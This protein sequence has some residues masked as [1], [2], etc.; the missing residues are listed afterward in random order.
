MNC[1]YYDSLTSKT[2]T[3]KDIFDIYI[4]ISQGTFQ[5]QTDFIQNKWEQE[6][7]FGFDNNQKT[8][9]QDDKKNMLPCVVFSGCYD[10]YKSIEEQTAV[11]HSGRMNMDIDMN[12]RIEL[13]E[14]NKVVLSGR[15][16]FIEACG[17]SVSGKFN[18]SMWINVLIELP[19]SYNELTEYI[20]DKLKL[21][22]D[23]YISKIHTTYYEFFSD[24]LY[25]ELKIVAGN[26]KEVKRLRYLS[27]DSD[28]FINYEAKYLDLKMLET[29]LKILPTKNM[30]EE[31]NNEFA[32]EDDLF[33]IAVKYAEN[34]VGKCVSGNIHNYVFYFCVITN[35]MGIPEK[36]AKK[37]V[38]EKLKVEVKTNCVEFP[39]KSYRND[40]GVFKPKPRPISESGTNSATERKSE[41][42]ENI[43]FRYLGFTKQSDNV[44]LFNFYVF[45]SKTILSLPASK[46]NKSNLYTLAPINYWQTNYP[47]KNG[48]DIDAAVNHIIENSNRIG[49]F[50][51][52]KIRGRGAWID[53]GRIV[54]HCGS[55]L[56]VDN[57]QFALGD[58]DTEYWYELQHP[59]NLTTANPLTKDESH[60]ILETIQKLSWVRDVDCIL[61]GGWVALA[62]ICGVLNWRPHIW[63]TG[64][65]GSGKSWVNREI[66][67]KF[68]K[69]ISISVQGNTSEA[70]LREFIGNDAIN[71]LF[72]E[73]EGEN[74]HAQIQIQKVLQLMRSASSS[75]G[76]VIAKG[77][78]SGAKTY[79]I[80]SCF[81]FCSIVP[82]AIHNSDLRRITILELKK[83][84]LNNENFIELE[85]EFRK[86]ATDDFV[87]RFQSRIINLIPQILKTIEVF[88]NVITE[89]LANRAMGDQLGAL[90]GGCW[91]LSNDEIA[92]IDDVL[93]LINDIDFSE[94]QGLNAVTDE[95]KC[96][97]HILSI[98]IRVDTDHTGQHTRTVGE[99]LEI[100]DECVYG[101]SAPVS[102]RT[103]E[104]VLKRNGIKLEDDFIFINPDSSVLQGYLKNTSWTK[105][106]GQIL[107]RIKDAEKVKRTYYSTGI[108]AK[109]VKI[110]FKPI[111]EH[112]K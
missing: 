82:Q 21:K 74:E 30:E 66:L 86:F 56:L 48:F 3:K 23:N 77:T 75:D 106:Y 33:K 60:K 12:N 89:K 99:L 76:G 98:Q 50:N 85:K 34:K 24:L 90:L 44:Q 53:K 108:Y 58:I 41:T 13:D 92:T 68:T 27:H 93:S 25:K 38:E 87:K 1:N 83:G 104:K 22:E 45:G 39:Y 64:G 4:D 97:Q 19:K 15:I 11:Q 95:I 65:A 7:Q 102:S 80:K 20:I 31:I 32:E 37:F 57:N 107:S 62:P 79:Q 40:F 88:T 81:A 35:R 72:D 84:K 51:P 8:E 100:Q 78:G 49:Y 2:A 94:E 70:G 111:L 101:D 52:N 47:K 112:E 61:L 73:A 63:I 36:D 59:L 6:L 109:A 46:L 71:V 14:F 54:I 55:H 18:G 17:K 110:P 16:P 5:K 103:A 26:T 96:L 91:H 105:N 43:Y 42:L 28:I 29:W 67:Q 9:Y 69:D 10:R